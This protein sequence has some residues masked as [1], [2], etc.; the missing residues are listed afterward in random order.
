MNLVA[1]ALGLLV[2]MAFAQD[3]CAHI[4]GGCPPENVLVERTIPYA[5]ELILRIAGGLGVLMIAWAGFQMFLAL[6]DDSKVSKARMGVLYAMFGL[7]LAGGSQLLVGFTVTEPTVAALQGNFSDVTAFA[8]AANIIVI[9]LDIFFF[10]VILYA[11]IRMAFGQGKDDEM[12]KARGMIFAAV[13]GAIIVNLARVL[14][15]AALGIFG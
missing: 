5:G 4:P 6:G 9:L 14:A 10:L 13:M 7:M 15:E 8:G 2:P 12:Q 11:A 1:L 3:P